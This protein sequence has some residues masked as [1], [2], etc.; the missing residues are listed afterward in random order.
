MKRI[1][2]TVLGLAV[3]LMLGTLVQASPFEKP[4]ESN[5]PGWVTAFPY[6]RNIDWTFATDPR[7]GP[8]PNGAPGA[9]YEGYDDPVLWDSDF[10]QLGGDAQ[11]YEDLSSFGMPWQGMIGMINNTTAP[12]SGELRIHV[13]NWERLWPFKHVWI[14]FDYIA[15][16][17]EVVDTVDLSMVSS[18]GSEVVD[19]GQSDAWFLPTQLFRQ[20]AWAYIV[21][22][23]LWEELVL[24]IEGLQPGDFI[25]MDRLHIATE[26]VPEPGT[27]ALGGLAI[28]GLVAFARRRRP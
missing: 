5:M 18:A 2:V 15:N 6:Q 21:P 7:G 24:K 16:R 28:I 14:E 22:N 20:N 8:T 3:V 11:W 1:T 23:P 13:D 12:M 9:H 25:L 26:C 19:D 4:P 17:P 27:F 10:I